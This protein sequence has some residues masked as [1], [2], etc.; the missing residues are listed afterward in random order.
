MSLNYMAYAK[1]VRK[2]AWLREIIG[3][4]GEIAEE[5]YKPDAD[6]ETVAGNAVRKLLS[7]RQYSKRKT[8]NDAVGKAAEYIEKIEAGIDLGGLDPVLPTIR[9][10]VANGRLPPKEMTI[11]AAGPGLGKTMIGL[12]I[13]VANVLAGRR[14]A[15]VGTEMDLLL[16]GLRMIPQ[17][18]NI[19]PLLNDDE[20]VGRAA[21]YF[22]GTFTSEDLMAGGL[23]KDVRALEQK[24]RDSEDGDR[25]VIIDDLSDVD[26]VIAR[27]Q[28]EEMRHGQLDGVVI[29]YLQMLDAA[30]ESSRYMSET[31]RD[32]AVGTALLNYSNT[33]SAH[34]VA[35]SSMRK[36][37]KGKTKPNLEDVRGTR[38]FSYD[39]G[40]ALILYQDEATVATDDWDR[41]YALV[42][43][44]TR[45][46]RPKHAH[47]GLAFPIAV[48]KET[49]L[50]IEFQKEM[51]GN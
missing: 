33:T 8:L 21:A 23:S 40:L 5:A 6:P 37:A 9:G 45:F 29:D 7:R 11:I 24:L 2:H 20:T 3:W 48:D 47:Q 14:M 16:L 44:N 28:A 49:A 38:K 42:A 46:C 12:M 27:L 36:L 34:I 35:V 13:C 50:V 39:T 51:L 19:M 17:L 26:E 22:D 4:V 31:Q 25:L 32:D 10:I 43:K 1:R 15:Y 18:T 41:T 30:S